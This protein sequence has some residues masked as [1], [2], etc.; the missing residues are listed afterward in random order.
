[1]TEHDVQLTIQKAKEK[2]PEAKGKLITDN[3][4]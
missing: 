2:Y 4:A 3:G 1:M